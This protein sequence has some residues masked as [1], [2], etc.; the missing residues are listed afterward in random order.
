MKKLLILSMV[1]G[2]SSYASAALSWSVTGGTGPGGSVN[3]GD[4]LTLSLDCPDDYVTEIVI[5]WIT[6]GN[7][8]GGLFTGSSV[9]PGFNNVISAGMS[10]ADL[11]SMLTAYGY[12]PTGKPTDDWC[13]IDALSTSATPPTGSGILTLDYTVGLIQNITQ[14]QP[15]LTIICLL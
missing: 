3:P 9:H 2:L 7:P 14:F 13:W 8:T 4:N 12:L 1:L 10:V 6:D 15:P 11:D 5:D